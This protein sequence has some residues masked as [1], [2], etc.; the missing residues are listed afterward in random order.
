M[1]PSTKRCTGCEQTK[2]LD[3]FYQRATGVREARCKDCERARVNS[4]NKANRAGRTEYQRRWRDGK[5]PA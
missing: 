1:T 4:Y 2:P 5:R 3:A